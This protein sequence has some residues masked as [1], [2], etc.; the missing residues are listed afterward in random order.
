[1][2]ETKNVAIDAIAQ[3]NSVNMQTEMNAINQFIQV[4]PTIFDKDIQNTV[5]Y[6]NKETQ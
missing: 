1:M 5:E 6:Q 3:F 2:L 4:K